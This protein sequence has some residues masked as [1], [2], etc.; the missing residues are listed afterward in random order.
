MFM[1]MFSHFE[2]SQAQK[3]SFSFGLGPVKNGNP[4]V[5]NEGT[6]SSSSE[7][8]TTAKDQKT[9]SLPGGDKENPTRS[10]TRFA[11]ELDGLHCFEC[12]IPSK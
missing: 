5:S 1:S 6:A 7:T 10:R 2:I 8:K 4:K 9:S 12:I 3:W 11:P